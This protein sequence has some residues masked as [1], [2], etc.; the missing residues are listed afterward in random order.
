MFTKLVRNVGT[1]VLTGVLLK[2]QV[3]WNLTFMAE[4]SSIT[5]SN[6]RGQEFS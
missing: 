4:V 5:G 1:E 6:S 3:C 2:I